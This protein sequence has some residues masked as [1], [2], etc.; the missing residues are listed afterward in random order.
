[1]TKL[2]TGLTRLAGFEVKVIRDETG[3][4]AVAAG[5]RDMIG[6]AQYATGRKLPAVGYDMTTHESWALLS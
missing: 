1:M 5:R 3:L 4:Y 2:E 6:L